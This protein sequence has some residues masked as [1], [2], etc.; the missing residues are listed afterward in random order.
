M[1]NTTL[2]NRCHLRR[3]QSVSTFPF[4][5]LVRLLRLH[6]GGSLFSFFLLLFC[7]RA[8]TQSTSPRARH[9]GRARRRRKCQRAMGGRG[10]LARRA[11]AVLVA[12]RRVCL[13]TRGKH[14]R[15]LSGL[16]V[17]GW[18]SHVRVYKGRLG[19]LNKVQAVLIFA[20]KLNFIERAS[21]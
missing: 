13:E 7:V 1:Y 14:E 8:C 19:L 17:W 10:G 18:I 3:I 12:R 2:T 16:L 20:T 4:R 21:Y 5:Y 15:A 6:A 9:R 11:V